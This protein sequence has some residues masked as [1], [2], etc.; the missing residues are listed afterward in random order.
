MIGRGP[1][2]NKDSK[3]LIVIPVEQIKL[4]L[5]ITYNSRKIHTWMQKKI[6]KILKYV[7]SFALSN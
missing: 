5:W 6:S 1:E 7:L 4:I 2:Y 3:E